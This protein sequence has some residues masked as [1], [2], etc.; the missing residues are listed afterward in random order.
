MCPIVEVKGLPTLKPRGDQAPSWEDA[1]GSCFTVRALPRPVPPWLVLGSLLEEAETWLPIQCTWLNHFFP[2]GIRRRSGQRG[3]GPLRIRDASLY[4]GPRA[5]FQH[6]FRGVPSREEQAVILGV[7]L[8][9]VQSLW[10]RPPSLC[11]IKP[12]P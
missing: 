10:T 9:L 6:G 4:P 1:Q 2:S 12:T 3:K 11:S 7:F 8:T 5:P